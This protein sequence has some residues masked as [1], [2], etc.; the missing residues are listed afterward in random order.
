MQVI[1]GLFSMFL[2]LSI[3]YL[4]SANSELQHNVSD[5]S[6]FPSHLLLLLTKTS[7]MTICSH[8]ALFIGTLHKILLAR[9]LG[10]IHNILTFNMIQ[11][12]FWKTQNTSGLVTSFHCT[13]K[14]LIRYI[15]AKVGNIFLS[16]M[17]GD[18]LTCINNSYPLIPS[19]PLSSSFLSVSGPKSN[20]QISGQ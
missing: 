10:W 18:A 3:V 17:K 16:G 9:N 4:M 7:F 19:L 5:G 14:S 20:F 6:P 13:C 15:E 2:Y 1:T 11:A 12:N 8:S